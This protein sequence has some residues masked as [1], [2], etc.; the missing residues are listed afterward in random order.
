MNILINAKHAI[1]QDKGTITIET[2][3]NSEFVFL[4]ITDTGFAMDDKTKKGCLTLFS[5]QKK[6]VWEQ[7]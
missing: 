1:N 3:A 7:G 4:H 6:L 2:F 5:L